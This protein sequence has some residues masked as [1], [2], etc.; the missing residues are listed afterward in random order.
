MW[1]TSITNGSSSLME[2]L[3]AFH[4]HTMFILVFIGSLISFYV[5]FLMMSKMTNRS[6]V[7]NEGLE[8]VWTVFPAIILIVI[9]LPSLKILYI[10][11]ST[12][13]PCITIKAMG[14]QWYWSYEF[15][16]D[17]GFEFDSYMSPSDGGGDDSRLYDVDNRVVTIKDMTMRVVCSS[18]D[19]IHS[20]TVPAL[21]VKVDAN[22]GRLNQCMIEPTRFGI[23]YGQCS[24]VCGALHAFMP[25]AVEVTSWELFLTWAELWGK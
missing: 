4:D 23:F 9:G 21:G 17:G 25:I 2:Q 22:P 7:L 8:V 24:E 11:E 10:M 20:W 3:S 5:L 15:P 6:I 14:H 18:T 16:L 12:T 19:V 1:M 13:N